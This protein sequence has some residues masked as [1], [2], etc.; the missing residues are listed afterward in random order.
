MLPGTLDFQI[1]A[2]GYARFWS[3]DA[4]SEYD[5]APYF[6]RKDFQQNYGGIGFDL[7]PGM[8]PVKT[9]SLPVFIAGK[10]IAWLELKA[11]A[12]MHPRPHCPQ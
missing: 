5:H 9:V 6:Y 8:A 7:K 11:D 4:N 1:E 3:A 10:I 12:V 2:A